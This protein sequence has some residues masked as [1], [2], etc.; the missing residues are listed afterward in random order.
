VT[1]PSR[2]AIERAAVLAGEAA[3]SPAASVAFDMPRSPT[4]AGDI[5]AAADAFEWAIAQ[6]VPESVAAYLVAATAILL[7]AEAAEKEAKRR[8]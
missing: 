8:Q 4:I 2:G 7:S 1:R 6:G 3:V 5:R